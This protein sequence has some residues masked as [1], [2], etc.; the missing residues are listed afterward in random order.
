MAYFS[1]ISG[2]RFAP[3]EHVGGAWDLET[4]HIA[5][6]LGLLVHAVEQ[7]AARRGVTGLRISRLSYDI[8]GTVPI[9]EVDV[10]VEVVRP[11]RT[12]E[13]VEAKLSYLGRTI[14]ALR[15]WLL[16]SSDTAGVAGTTFAGIPGPE[17]LPEWRP[18]AVWPG[19]FIASAQVRRS[20]TEPGNAVYWV[21]TSEPLIAGEEVSVLAARAGLFDISNGMTVRADPT[22]VAFPNVDLTAHLFRYPVGEWLGFETHVSFGPDGS[23]LTHSVLHDQNGPF[24]SSSQSLTVRPSSGTVG[25]SA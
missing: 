19:G 5:P 22:L 9:T 14:V 7:D 8:F 15:A 24:G 23:G 25:G 12:V 11:G 17:A 4:Q 10:T 1:R 2:T 6:S 13:L 3:T 18:G 20:E 16:Q 21:R